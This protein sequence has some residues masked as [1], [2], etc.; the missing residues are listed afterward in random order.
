M[1][2]TRRQVRQP[3]E[4][5]GDL[6]ACRI[7][8]ERVDGEVAPRRILA[9]VVG[10]GNGG[11]PAVGR[12]IAAQG[13]DLHRTA[14]EDRGDRAVSD[15]GRHVADPRRVEPRLDLGRRQRRR[16]VDVLDLQAEQRVAHRAADIARHAGP[17]HGDQPGEILAAG[18]GGLGKAFS[19]AS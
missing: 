2:R 11:A 17:Q 4:P 5:V 18:P 12:D 8:V 16:Q 3:A 9:P 13:G 6:A 19:H 14:L 1:K 10:E 15:A 7:G